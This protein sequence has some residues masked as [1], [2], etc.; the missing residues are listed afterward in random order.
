MRIHTCLAAAAIAT[1]LAGCYTYPVYQPVAVQRL[2]PAQSAALND[3]QQMSQA[4]RDR[5]AR[6]NAQVARED[7]AAQTYTYAAPAAPVY[8]PPAA[9]YDGYANYP[10][11]YGGYPYYYGAYPFYPAIG[12][13]FG[14]GG[15]WGGHGGFHHGGGFHGRH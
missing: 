5:F 14:F 8:Y 2:T 10:Y 7:Q 4:D 3:Q 11:Y 15:R 9:Y 1:A 6:D 13:S 12:L